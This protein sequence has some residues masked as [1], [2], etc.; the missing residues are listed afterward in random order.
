MGYRVLT[1]KWITRALVREHRD[2][3]FLFGDSL[4]WQGFGGQAAAMRGEPNV[5]GIPTKKLPSN[6]ENAFFMDAEFEQNKAAIDQAFERLSV[7]CLATDQVIVIP[8]NG[9]G[10]GRAQLQS[11]APLTFAYLQK[12]LEDLS[13]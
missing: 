7:I 2:R 5:I 3:I 4:A 13:L 11:R 6:S 1:M 10:T 12:R 8:A 9:I